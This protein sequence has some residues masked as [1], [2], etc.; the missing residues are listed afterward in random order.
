MMY[1]L[2]S[3]YHPEINRIQY[4]Q[5]ARI[6]MQP[7]IQMSPNNDQMTP[8]V[9]PPYFMLGGSSLSTTYMPMVPL[10]SLND[11]QSQSTTPLS[12]SPQ[13]RWNAGH[14]MALTLD[15][16]MVYNCNFLGQ[17]QG[18]YEIETPEGL[19]QVSVIVPSLAD[20]EE[21][22]AIVRRVC[23]DGEALPDQF[24]YQEPN[25][26]T[27]CSVNGTVEAEFRMGSSMK[28]IVTW[29]NAFS[30]TQTVWRRKGEVIFNL[31]SA[32]SL[33]TSR[34]NSLSS[35]CSAS[36]SVSSVVNSPFN[37]HSA[38]SMQIRPELSNQSSV[39]ENRSGHTNGDSSGSSILKQG[40]LPNLDSRE[41]I[42]TD[43]AKDHQEEAIFELIKAHCVRS[44]CLLRRM[45]Q[46]AM[47]NVAM[48][49]VSPVDLS[50]FSAGRLWVTAH[51]ARIEDGVQIEEC[52]QDSLDDI[53][54]AYKEIR[55]NVYMQPEPQVNEPGVQ[56][57]LMKDSN[58]YWKIEFQDVESGKW[59]M[60]V[61]ELADGRWTDIKNNHT[62][63]LI[64]LVPMSK[65]LKKLLVQF[66][67]EKQELERNVTFLFTQ[68][69]QKKLN[70]KLK[71][72]NLK[73]NILTL[74]DKLEKQH[75]L[76]FSVQVATMADII[77]QEIGS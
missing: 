13:V 76:R 25:R 31:V 49:S 6:L 21:P 33:A 43:Q 24:I 38:M 77:A 22:Y 7:A 35:I 23:S 30:R 3:S 45:V 53:K 64:K 42:C 11:Y 69:N 28:H 67:A 51:P 20:G 34:R 40:S 68:C 17:L 55:S 63:V 74:K 44:S 36:T 61:R 39:S 57:R 62:E 72:R 16:E 65:V 8:N 10:I 5:A 15:N 4:N 2:T 41:L 12:S 27:L 60:C 14:Q 73:S 56:H 18:N 9:S 66:P 32:N 19:D 52:V 37:R 54:G 58:G 48:R 50:N 70:S 59:I 47:R 1:Q 46:W 71:G 29:E 26:F 75:L